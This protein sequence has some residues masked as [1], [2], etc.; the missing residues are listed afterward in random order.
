[1]T[2]RSHHAMKVLQAFGKT[3]AQAQAYAEKKGIEATQEH[4]VSGFPVQLPRPA[5][6]LSALMRQSAELHEQAREI[7]S[8]LEKDSGKLLMGQKRRHYNQTMVRLERNSKLINGLLQKNVIPSSTTEA[9]VKPAKPKTKKV[10]KKASPTKKVSKKSP[11]SKK[12]NLP[13]VSELHAMKKEE[14]QS[15]AK[16]FGFTVT[17]KITKAQL[18]GTLSEELNLEE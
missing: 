6:I 13:T 14:V 15:T 3:T 12:S 17:T 4:L 18:I 2:R 11:K 9:P 16:T 7:L 1:M 10:S 5:G 8:D